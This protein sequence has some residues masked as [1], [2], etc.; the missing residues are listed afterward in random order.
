MEIFSPMEEAVE[1]VQ[2]RFNAGLFGQ[3]TEYMGQPNKVKDDMWL[4]IVEHGMV[5]IPAET[6]LRVNNESGPW[7]EK[8]GYHMFG[9]E[10]YHQLHCLNTMRIALWKE[11]P[12][13]MY[14]HEGE[15]GFEHM[16]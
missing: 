4:D 6:A 8:P 5:A 12:D 1:W 7:E 3:K 10:M 9:T 16:V 2:Y 14:G 11:V 13:V 15:G